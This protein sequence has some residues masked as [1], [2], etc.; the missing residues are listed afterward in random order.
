MKKVIIAE[1]PSLGKN[2]A[3]A[4][5][6]SYKRLN[7]YYE[8]DDYLITYAYGHLFSLY[9]IEQYQD[10]YDPN[11]KV[12][13]TLNNL[14]FFPK[15]FKF[16]LKRDDG[17]ISQ[18]KII[19]DLVNR[20][21][22]DLIINAGD[23]D[24]EGEIIIR[25]ILSY[26]LKSN[27][28]IKRLWMPDQTQ[29]TILKELVELKDDSFYDSLANEGYARTYIDWLYGIN[30]TRLATI[31]SHTLLRVGRVISPIVKAIYDREMQIVN[32]VKTKYYVLQSK[33][34][35]NDEEVELVSSK[36]FSKDEY[37]KIINLAKI[38]NQEKAIVTNIKNEEKTIPSPRL[39]SLSKLQGVMGK[40]FKMSPDKTLQVAQSLYEKGYISYPRTPSEY[41]GE[42][43]KGKFKEII[44]N[45]KHLM[46][47]IMF[48]DNK[49]IF[50]DSKIESHSALTPTYIIPKKSDLS[51]D[52]YHVY[53]T[54]THRFF[55]VFASSLCKVAKSNMEIKLGDLETF[56]LNGEIMLQKGW[57]A[58]EERDKKDKSLPNLKIGDIV[59]VNFK[60]LEKET[61]PPR[62]YSVDSLNNFLKNPF[63]EQ[64]DNKD[65]DNPYDDDFRAVLEGIEL[66]TEATRAGIISNAIKQKYIALKDNVY[67]LLDMGKYYIE[68]LEDLSL[69]MEKEKTALIGKSLKQVYR[70][71]ITLVDAVNL[72]QQ[73]IINLFNKSKDKEIKQAPMTF[74]LDKS[75]ILCKCPKCNNY[76]GI[77]D[78]GYR[79]NYSPCGLSLYKDNA[80]FKTLNKT[81]TNKVAK[82]IFTKGEITYDD[83]VSKKGTTYKATLKANFESKYVSF[84]FNFHSKNEENK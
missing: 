6:S 74:N 67:S 51:I 34:K 66:G 55:A 45:F 52:E 56:K 49:Y 25:I 14:P 37:D 77:Y 38:Y 20:N 21:D 44:D 42:N 78:Y 28:P 75:K 76:I 31:K 24:R 10:N 61:K 13:W 72:S 3:A 64:L 30:L 53:E 12:S 16:G 82:E 15:D 2:I 23:S 62:R 33:E 65:D 80:L 63:K 11:K 36:E 18:F 73:E 29:K 50:D 7:G 39:F 69:L 81:I 27:K 68:T 17:T 43:E 54:I 70:G 41:L 71:E 40:K 46:I 26:A 5:S 8:A 4:I 47:D 9:D 32:F 59:N 60:P 1:K 83:L 79:C 84:T 48:K 58:F 35:T 22:V 19:R 57:T